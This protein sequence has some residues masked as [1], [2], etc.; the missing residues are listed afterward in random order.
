MKKI[1][2]LIIFLF[3][4]IIVA[5]DHYE[6]K[7]SLGQNSGN[8]WYKIATF[9]LAGNG[10]FNSIIVNAEINYVMT[11]L[12]G[13]TAKAQLIIR[14]NSGIGNAFWNYSIVGTEM[15][16]VV[17]FRKLS[18]T[19]FELYAKSGGGWGHLSAIITVTREAP[20]IVNLPTTAIVENPIAYEMIPKS[21]DFSF[22]SGNIGIGTAT[23]DSKLSVN[24]TIHA[25]KVKVDMVGWSDFV[26]DKAYNL[27]TLEEVEQHIQEKGH[28][29]DIPS[30][31]NVVNN[32]IDL[33]E[34]DAKLLQ[35]IEELTLYT[36]EQEKRIKT[37]EDNNQKFIELFEELI[38]EK[39][40]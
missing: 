32:G 15:G 14:E 16:D 13:Y 3:A 40:N 9:D 31:K 34:M 12:R 37:L 28:L 25:K 29:Q 10:S 11:S 39:S 27:P 38:K 19:V 20:L 2:Q 36:I 5:Q 1:I 35:K 17:E 4:T 8:Q 26:F 7:I 21:G 24:G 30:T 18:P 23:P 22:V 6:T 33:G